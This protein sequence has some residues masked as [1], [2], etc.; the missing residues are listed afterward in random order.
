MGKQHKPEGSKRVVKQ[1]QRPNELVIRTKRGAVDASE[2]SAVE[3]TLAKL[4]AAQTF[5]DAIAFAEPLQALRISRLIE[6]LKA[7]TYLSQM[8]VMHFEVIAFTTHHYLALPKIGNVHANQV[9]WSWFLDAMHQGSEVQESFEEEQDE[10]CMEI[11]PAFWSV[12]ERQIAKSTSLRKLLRDNLL[13]YMHNI[14]RTTDQMVV[15]FASLAHDVIDHCVETADAFINALCKSSFGVLCSLFF[16][17]IKR[18]TAVAL[19]Q[20]QWDACEDK[21]KMLKDIKNVRAALRTLYLY[22]Y[23]GYDN[24][25]DGYHSDSSDCVFLDVEKEDKMHFPFENSE[26]EHT[27]EVTAQ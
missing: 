27:S 9:V 21:G 24:L 3:S 25:D 5:E 7:S 17:Y 6:A 1:P 13:G 10:D 23:C 8:Q 16:G 18:D 20:S 11:T 26:A 12:V 15:Q 14:P 4:V 22:Q 19:L 2:V